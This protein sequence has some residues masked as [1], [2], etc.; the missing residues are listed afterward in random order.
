MIKSLPKYA[1]TYFNNVLPCSFD[2]QICDSD[3][4]CSCNIGGCFLSYFTFSSFDLN[5]GTVSSLGGVTTLS[6]YEDILFAV[7][8]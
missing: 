3:G 5:T 8:I 6:I 2:S 4:Y 1:M 7:L